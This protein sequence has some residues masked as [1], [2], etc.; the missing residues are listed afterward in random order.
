[1][2]A[3]IRTNAVRLAVR[4]L[5]DKAREYLFRRAIIGFSPTVPLV[6]LPLMLN[7]DGISLERKQRPVPFGRFSTRNFG[8]RT[9]HVMG[10]RKSNPSRPDTQMPHIVGYRWRATTSAWGDPSA[11][12]NT[13]EF[14]RPQIRPTVHDILFAS[15]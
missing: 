4:P 1:M 13:L 12:A 6:D 2:D 10:P 9:L 8:T 7:P 11:T 5:E 3:S 14:G 15:W